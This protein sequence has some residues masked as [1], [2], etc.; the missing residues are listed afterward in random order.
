MGCS[1]AY[2]LAHHHLYDAKAHSITL[3][4]ATEI[5]G[6]ASGKAGGLVAD[7]ATPKCLAPLSFRTH[8][9]LA[10]RHDG[11]KAWGF[12]RVHC[13]DVELR[14][15]KPKDGPE[16]A[17][18]VPAGEAAHPDDLDWLAEGSIRSYDEVGSPQ[19][20]AQVDPPRL[21]R[22]IARLAEVAGAEIIMGSA[23]SVNYREDGK[24]VDS[25]TY[26]ANGQSETLEA[27]DI[28]V[29]TGP[30]TPRLLPSVK[31]LAP[32]GH[33]VIA[34]PSKKLSPY[35]LFTTIEAAPG[36]GPDTVVSPEI[37]PRPPDDQSPQGTVY[38][39]G[40]DDHRVPLPASTALVEVDAVK[41]QKVWT[42]M[43]SVSGV[44]RDAEIV[45]RQA[46]YKAQIRPHDDG[47]EVG[48][49]LGATDTKGLWIATGLDEWGMQNGPGAGRVLSEM[50]LE[51]KSRSAD[52]ESLDPRHFLTTA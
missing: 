24:A 5:A 37:Y 23:T 8:G 18:P 38:A 48:P 11:A 12:R 29:A 32:R 41:C 46:C 50:I 31:L 1:T 2:F 14:A 22:A 4:E 33:S 34:R 28:V 51:G 47:E 27:T 19:N 6:G 40:P 43:S 20:S 13:A 3:L 16:E 15:Q 36:G 52:C 39:C 49:I 9:E 17:N 44:I 7:W 42:G 25:V 45:T 21:T 30:W 26:S 35:V 10:K